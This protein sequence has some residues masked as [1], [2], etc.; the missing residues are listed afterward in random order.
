MNRRTDSSPARPE[1]GP[2]VTVHTPWLSSF[3][4]DYENFLQL[5]YDSTGV[6][7]PINPQDVLLLDITYLEGI[8]GLE[9]GQNMFESIAIFKKGFQYNTEDTMGLCRNTRVK[10]NANVEGYVDVKRI[11]IITGALLDMRIPRSSIDPPPE[12]SV[13]D[14]RNGIALI[15]L[16]STGL[17]IWLRRLLQHGHSEIHEVICTTK[18]KESV[19]VVQLSPF[20]WIE[21]DEDRFLFHYRDNYLPLPLDASVENVDFSWKLKMP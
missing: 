7:A 12:G 17:D 2:Q 18:A 5:T 8:C 15:D 9:Q 16:E 13:V 19:L 20:S 3:P 14:F 11:Q 1:L 21:R 10:A 4:E 6:E